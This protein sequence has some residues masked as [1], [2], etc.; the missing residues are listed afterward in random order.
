VTLDDSSFPATIYARLI[1]EE[2]GM[3]N[4]IWSR[5]KPVV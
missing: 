2:D 3:H 1:E 4:L 5:G